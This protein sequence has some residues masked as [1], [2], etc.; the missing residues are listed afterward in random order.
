MR[1]YVDWHPFEYYTC[2]LSATGRLG[3]IWRATIETMEFVALEG[4][5]ARVEHRYRAEQR[6][7][8]SFLAYRAIM[9]A[10]R[11]GL[12][13]AGMRLRTIMDEDAAVLSLDDES[14]ASEPQ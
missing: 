3:I 11:A 13:S 7:G 4:G 2:R 14:R 8:I 1:D 10:M 5:G 6:S 9:L 12:R